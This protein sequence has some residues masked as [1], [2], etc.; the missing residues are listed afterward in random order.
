VIGFRANIGEQRVPGVENERWSEVARDGTRLS[1]RGAPAAHG[2]LPT[3]TATIIAYLFP[4]DDTKVAA[5]ADAASVA[6]P[7]RRPLSQ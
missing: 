6:D 7:A 1:D 2:C 5:L 3:A 4:R